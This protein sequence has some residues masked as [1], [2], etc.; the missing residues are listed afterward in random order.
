MKKL[1]TLLI[2][3]GMFSA[4]LVFHDEIVNY[5]VEKIE[6][7]DRNLKS[8][9]KLETNKYSLNKDYEFIKISNNFY[10]KN[11]DDIKN[12]YYTILD[13][14]MTNF[15]FYC[16]KNYKSCIDDVDYI[17]NNQKLLSYINDFVPVYNSFKNIETEF[18]NLGQISI[19]INHVYN[20][21]DNKL[22][23]LK[24]D[25]IIKSEITDDMN[26]ETKIKVIH[27][28]II[29]NTKYDINRSDNGDTTYHSDTAYGVLIEGY[30]I[31]GGY[32]DS[33]KLFLDKLNIPNFKIS[34]ENH[35]WNAAYVN[36]KWLHLDLTWDD[37]VD[38]NGND[39]LEYNYFLIDTDELLTQEKEQHMFDKDVFR[40]FKEN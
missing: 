4:S 33:M 18:D 10:P 2:L 19:K 6:N 1:I 38:K 39:I 12:I 28:Y 16:D 21:H 40:E 32:A 24:I 29:N 25:E 36:N 27:D 8:P 5:V 3:V 14:G 23:N 35:I 17:S 31:C 15:T 11:Q 37:P 26:D 34:S 30:A 7:F 13:S 22:I 9:T 20:E